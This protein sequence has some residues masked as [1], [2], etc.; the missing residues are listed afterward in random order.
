MAKINKSL[1]I[2]I[3]LY[4]I[5]IALI[6]CA[7]IYF[8]F[9]SKKIFSCMSDPLTFLGILSSVSLAIL[10]MLGQIYEKKSLKNTHNHIVFESQVKEHITT[11]TVRIILMIIP[12]V[13]NTFFSISQLQNNYTATIQLSLTGAALILSLS[14][15]IKYARLLK[16]NV[17]IAYSDAEKRRNDEKKDELEDLENL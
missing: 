15:P 6:V 16:S 11:E 5:Y 2:S 8:A 7:C 1:V 3:F 10:G 14:L 17:S 13:T 4:F 12:I 9:D